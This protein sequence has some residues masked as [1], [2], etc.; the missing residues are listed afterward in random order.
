MKRKHEGVIVVE[1]L[2]QLKSVTLIE[3]VEADD[4]LQLCGWRS[5]PLEI[6][7]FILAFAFDEVTAAII[8]FVCHQWNNRKTYWVSP[9]SLFLS[10]HSLHSPLSSFPF[11]PFSSHFLFLFIP[12]FIVCSPFASLHSPSS[13]FLFSSLVPI[14]SLLTV[15]SPSVFFSF[16]LEYKGKATNNSRKHLLTEF[17]D[18]LSCC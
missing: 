5:L 13:F 9:F 11:F 16:P 6:A 10:F 7:D 2:Q 3:T 8:P 17:E 12:F 14:F 15:L 4:P 18:M 1:R